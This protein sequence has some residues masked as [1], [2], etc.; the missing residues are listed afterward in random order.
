MPVTIEDRPTQA[1]RDE[2][3]DKLIMNYS[4]GHLSYEA[5]ERRLDIAME[6]QDNIEIAK[7]AEDLDLVVDKAYVESKK[8]SMFYTSEGADS[9]DRDTLVHIFSGSERKGVWKVAKEIRV[10]SIFSGAEIDFSEAL[11][12]HKTTTIKVFSLFSGDD[13]YVPEN[14]NVVS[15]VFCIFGGVENKAP[16]LA[17]QN[18]P[19][20]VIEGFAI[21]SGIDIKIKQSLKERFVAFADNLKKMFN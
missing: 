2:V 16:C 18:S 3:V 14:I 15:K 20:L 21:F 8:K 12:G 10:F 9:E 6:S 17:D 1:V 4:H 5:F 11:F 13:I 19:T 7:Q